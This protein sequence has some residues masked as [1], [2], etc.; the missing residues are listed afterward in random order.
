MERVDAQN[1]GYF[2][3]CMHIVISLM[4]ILYIYIFG[5][6]ICE[7]WNW[8]G[9]MVDF[10]CLIASVSRKHFGVIGIIKNK[11]TALK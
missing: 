2:L 4:L 3:A 11:N 9:V 1:D 8:N 7:A 5:F 10:L 6:G